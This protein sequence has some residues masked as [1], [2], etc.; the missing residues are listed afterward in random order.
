MCAGL[1]SSGM[2]Y[3]GLQ[4]SMDAE[5]QWL[6]SKGI[7]HNWSGSTEM[8]GKGKE[9]VGYKKDVVILTMTGCHGQRSR[10]QKDSKLKH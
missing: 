5:S 2:I 9:Q 1:M 7:C 8:G 6:E 3:H 4:S 10:H